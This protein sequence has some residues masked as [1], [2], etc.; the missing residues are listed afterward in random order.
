MNVITLAWDCPV[1]LYPPRGTEVGRG[2]LPRRWSAF[3]PNRE[4]WFGVNELIDVALTPSQTRR[5]AELSGPLHD[6][7]VAHAW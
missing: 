3:T 4:M 6:D 5:I 7:E 2:P 1:I